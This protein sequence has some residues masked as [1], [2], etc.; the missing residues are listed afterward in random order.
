[1]L[2][3]VDHA[4]AALAQPA[5][6]AVAGPRPAAA[7][8]RA[9]DGARPQHLLVAR[10]EGKARRAS[11]AAAR[12]LPSTIALWLVP[13]KE[14]PR[15]AVRGF[16]RYRTVWTSGDRRVPP[17]MAQ[18]RVSTLRHLTVGAAGILNRNDVAPVHWDPNRDG[19][20]TEGVRTRPRAAKYFAMWDTPKWGIIAGTY[21]VGFGQR[22]VFDTSR[23]YTPTATTSMTRSIAAPT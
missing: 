3:F 9:H 7:P 1:M 16:A 6:D 2:D 17:M 11:G 22:L 15:T 4:H 13:D 18:A 12:F 20:V 19:F 5:N 8:G 21:S 14:G 23:R 10:H